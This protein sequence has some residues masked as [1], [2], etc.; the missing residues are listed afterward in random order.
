[1]AVDSL[2][3]ERAILALISRNV[4]AWRRATGESQK[5]LAHVLGVSQVGVSD[6]LTGKTPW[7]FHDLASL[8]VH[9]NLTPMQLQGPTGSL[10]WDRLDPTVRFAQRTTR[11]GSKTRGFFRQYAD[12][13]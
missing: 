4:E 8:A 9:W 2:V 7:S 10:P 12:V 1:M 11:R 3:D 6:R 13:A 5:D